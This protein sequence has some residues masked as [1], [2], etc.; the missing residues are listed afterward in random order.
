MKEENKI[1]IEK[2]IKEICNCIKWKAVH[3]QIT[4]E[5]KD[6]LYEVIQEYQNEGIEEDQAVKK[7]FKQVGNAQEIGK[8]LNQ[9][10]KP[11]PD[12][13]ILILV[14]LF[15][16]IGLMALYFL[17]Q[18]AGDVGKYE[19]LSIEKSIFFIGVGITTGVF[20]YSFD[21]RKIQPYSKYLYGCTIFL[22]FFVLLQ[23]YQVN[24]STFLYFLGR[25]INI[26]EISPYLLIVSLAGIFANWDWKE[27]RKVF[28][29]MGLIV[30]P[31]LLISMGP[32]MVAASLFLV[33]IL[34]IMYYSGAK[35][36]YILGLPIGLFVMLVFMIGGKEEDWQGC[37]PFLIPI[38]TPMV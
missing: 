7:A 17:Q 21:Y 35:A 9:T 36:S 25:S 2:Y 34:V 14:S 11:A 16:S 10:H 18:Y 12:W 15:S 33:A 26:I 6:H 28:F 1:L 13:G 4:L 32:S 8:Q 27:P 3:G 37:L 22:L 29:A 5:I 23:G 20:F 38:E 31:I 24:G 30:V 19:S